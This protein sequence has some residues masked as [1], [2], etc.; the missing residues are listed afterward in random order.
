MAAGEAR[1]D[2]AAEIA[3]EA[4]E[5]ATR[6]M[7][8]AV[9]A[10]AAPERRAVVAPTGERTFA[11][12]DA[13]ANRLARALARRGVGPGDPVALLC[14]NRPEFV[15][16]YAACLRA[17][18]RLTPINWHL[19]AEEVGYIVAD[20]EA[21]ALVADARFAEL[22]RAAAEAAPRAEVRLAAGGAIPGFEPY[23]AALAAEAGED[24]AEPLLGGTMLYTSGTTGRPKG[25]HRGRPP[26]S[27]L[28]P[29]LLRTAAFDPATDTA[30]CT[31]PLYH[32]A[33]LALNLNVP[34][35]AGVGVVLM[36]RFDA[37]ETLRLVERHRVTHTHMV[38]T[39]FHRLLAL[40]EA[41]RARFD[42][43]SL[44]WVLHG[45]AP[46]PVHV[47]R[48]LLEWLGPVVY[49]YYAATEG[50][51]AFITPEEWLERPGSVGRPVEDDAIAVLD[52]AGRPLPPGE[53][54]T[55]YFRAPEE[56]RFEY[57]K[58]PEKTRSA[59]LG[60]HF[61]LGDQGRFD[62]AGY[63]YLTGR[64]AEVI[65]S[66]GVNVYPAEVDEVLLAHPAVAD[67]A[68][69]GAPNEEWGEEVRAVV[70]L[71]PGWRP[72]EAL[73]AEIRE[74]CRARLAHY[75]CPRVVDFTEEL[76]RLPTGKV[77]RRRL[78]ERYAREDGSA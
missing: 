70:E 52:E 41:T 26:R 12:L 77:L 20:C 25:V 31:G 32:A 4:R 42:L 30:L 44:R 6:G 56:G 75:K 38:P 43:S 64:S 59:Y 62:E 78:R 46:C 24:L 11:E 58:A 74:H 17:G 29:P 34:L 19:H 72:G 48:A 45:A 69:V 68:A 65:I 13:S 18:L 37:E 53:L 76:P 47:K 36:E 14:S 9:H 21:K 5:A 54:G 73:A 8:L 60:D 51:G 28:A 63:L 27:R 2:P 35:M 3:A 67:A 1:R 50:G 39:M 10:R 55:V 16:S 22:A 49:E 66:G 71:R 23:D 7:A 61:T 33:P 15:E 57:Y 40:P